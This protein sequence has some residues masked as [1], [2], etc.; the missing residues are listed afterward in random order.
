MSKGKGK[1][2]RRKRSASA[3]AVLCNRKPSKR[4]C[5]AEDQMVAAMNAV[6]GGSHIK[7]AAE[8]HG[9]PVTTLRD[10]ISG[11]VVH[12]TKPGPRP[13]LSTKEEAELSLFLKSCS[14]MGYGRTRTDVMGI[15][16]AVAAEKGTLKGSKVNQ[17]W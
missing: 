12:G 5:W 11:R 6:K 8:E 9:V 17:W 3:P 14:N 16:R 4:K 13:Y 15:A 7:R 2:T 1:Y 10:R